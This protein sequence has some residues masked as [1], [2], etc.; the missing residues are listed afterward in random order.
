MHV[1]DPAVILAPQ[2]TKT[3]WTMMSLLV[4]TA[5]IGIPQLSFPDQKGGHDLYGVTGYS[6]ALHSTFNSRLGDIACA[7][8]TQ[9]SGKAI[10]VRVSGLF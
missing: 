6:C 7:Y 2:N 1:A 3:N 10:T 4:F 5:L 9:L 8:Q